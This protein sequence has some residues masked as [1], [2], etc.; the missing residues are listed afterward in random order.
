MEKIT[1]SEKFSVGNDK[2]DGQHQVIINLINKLSELQ[3]LS[4]D[5]NEVRSIISDLVK[6]GLEHLQY[7]EDLLNQHDYPDFL[8]HKHEHILYIKKATKYM[9]NTS[10]IDEE[11][12]DQ[13]IIFLN[14]WWTHHILEEDMKYKSFLGKLN[15]T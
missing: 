10:A 13:I 4:F 3:G 15:L 5:K 14:D 1:W 8:K 7:E 9:K 12:L 6:Y 2:L 11:T